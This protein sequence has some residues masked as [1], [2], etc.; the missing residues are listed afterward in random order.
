MCPI[1][2]FQLHWSSDLVQFHKVRPW[3]CC[4]SVSISELGFSCK[5]CPLLFTCC[6]CLTGMICLSQFRKLVRHLR[7]ESKS[8]NSDFSIFRVPTLYALCCNHCDFF[9][10]VTSFPCVKFISLSRSSTNSNYISFRC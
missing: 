10:Q 5:L 4:S 9:T 6:K 1:T 7:T 3:V 8:Y 2:E